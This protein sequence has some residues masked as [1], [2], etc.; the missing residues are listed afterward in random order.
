MELDSACLCALGGSA[1]LF[2]L[3]AASRLR[4]VLVVLFRRPD[5]KDTKARRK[6]KTLSKLFCQGESKVA[7][8]SA[9]FGIQCVWILDRQKCTITLVAHPA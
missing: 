3:V 1:V 2:S 7:R 8:P 5:H 4:Q 9:Q 6:T